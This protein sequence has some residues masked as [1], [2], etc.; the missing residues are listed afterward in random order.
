MVIGGIAVIAH[1]VQRMTTDIDAVIQGD[2]VLV[3]TLI[4]QLRQHHIVTRVADAEAFAATNLVLLAR[5]HPTQIDLDLSLGW[6]IFEHEAIAAREMTRFGRVLVPM[7]AVDDLLVF[8]AIAGRPRDVDDAVTLL[9]LYPN[10][11]MIRV[12]AR[13]QALVRAAEAPEL[14]AGLERIISTFAAIRAPRSPDA[15]SRVRPRR[16]TVAAR[17]AVAPSPAKKSA[18]TKRAPTKRP[19]PSRK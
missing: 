3:R 15:K 4:A 10:I 1:G 14:E 12:R 19:K 6:T 7:A 18:P 5:H 16:S 8:K 9:T 2:A 11:D 17:K 13:V